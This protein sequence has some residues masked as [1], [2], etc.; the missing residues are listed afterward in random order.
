MN[1]FIFI[2]PNRN[3]PTSYHN[4]DAIRV[5]FSKEKNRNIY[6]LTI[7][8]GENLSEKIGVQSGDKVAIGYD[9]KNN[10]RMLLKKHTTGYSAFKVG[11]KNAPALRIVLK[12]II[13]VPTEIDMKIKEVEHEITGNNEL[14]FLV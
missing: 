12:W 4:K 14:I 7:Y 2:D 8:L 11:S 10:R 1:N 5:T 9:E 13:F 6:S 3:R